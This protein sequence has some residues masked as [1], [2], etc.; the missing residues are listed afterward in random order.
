MTIENYVTKE[1]IFDMDGTIADL[2]GVE[3]WLP[4]LRAEDVSPYAEARPLYD[5]DSL[6]SVLHVFKKAGYRIV[7]VSWGSK[8]AS[9]KYDKAVE[10]TKREWLEKYAFPADE[11]HIV[12]YETPKSKFIKNDLSVLIDDSAVVRNE[13]L[14][15]KSGMFRLAIDATENIISQLLKLLV[16]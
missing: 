9:E 12:P 5:M 3:D 11:I 13:F 8:G 2:Y 16:A 1:L 15:S 10:K 6:N 14:K 7:V 4:K